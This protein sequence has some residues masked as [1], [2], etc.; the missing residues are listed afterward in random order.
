VCS[1]AAGLGVNPYN[2]MYNSSYND[3]KNELETTITITMHKNNIQ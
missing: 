2:D 3:K 1:A